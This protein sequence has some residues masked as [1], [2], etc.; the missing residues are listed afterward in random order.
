M[1]WEKPLF[2]KDLSPPPK[3]TTPSHPARRDTQPWCEGE[4]PLLEEEFDSPP[5]R[6]G[7][8]MQGSGS[9]Q[10]I[11]GE[12]TPCLVRF[13]RAN[14]SSNLLYTSIR[15]VREGGC[16]WGRK[17]RSVPLLWILYV[18]FKKKPR[19]RGN[20]VA[21]L[22]GWVRKQKGVWQT[23]LSSFEVSFSG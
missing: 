8:I 1:A 15:R 22:R 6:N 12:K 11:R 9:I 23:F 13:S 4:S 2:R 3:A 17:S 7:I 20:N 21:C 19:N 10:H 5:S 16:P 18:F 14:C